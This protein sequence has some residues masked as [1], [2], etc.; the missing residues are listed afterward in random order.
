MGGISTHDQEKHREGNL[1]V[2]VSK[3]VL[4]MGRYC[5]EKTC[6]SESRSHQAPDEFSKAT[7]N[8]DSAKSIITILAGVVIGLPAN[9]DP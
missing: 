6:I 5:L 9:D 4:S 7:R 3:S 1:S 8:M 2:L